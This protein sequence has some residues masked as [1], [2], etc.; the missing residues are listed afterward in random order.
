MYERVCSFWRS[1]VPLFV[2]SLCVT[3][4]FH[5]RRFHCLQKKEKN[6]KKWFWLV[7]VYGTHSENSLTVL[8]AGGVIFTQSDG[9]KEHEEKNFIKKERLFEQKDIL[10]FRFSFF[11]SDPAV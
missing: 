7:R 4:V 3:L 1:L 8:L 11:V 5:S 10:V 2:R 9:I 6:E